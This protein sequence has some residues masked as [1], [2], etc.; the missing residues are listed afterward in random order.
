MDFNTSGAMYHQSDHAAE[1]VSD[2][3]AFAAF[4]FFTASYSETPPL[5]VVF[6]DW[7]STTPAVGFDFFPCRSRAVATRI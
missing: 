5:S 3:M 1:R 7:L 6:M 4:D 2:D